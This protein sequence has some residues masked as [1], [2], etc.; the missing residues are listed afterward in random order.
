MIF[1]LL[2]DPH[3]VSNESMEQVARKVVDM[4]K[5]DPRIEGFV[6]NGI[7]VRLPSLAS[8]CIQKQDE[9]WTQEMIAAFYREVQQNPTAFKRQ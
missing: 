8:F 6:Y 4:R 9:R 3:G 2:I 1:G 5:D 7:I